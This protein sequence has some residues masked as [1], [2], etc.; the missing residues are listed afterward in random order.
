LSIPTAPKDDVRSPKFDATALH[1]QSGLL[2]LRI[3]ID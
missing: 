3:K 2:E 1:Y